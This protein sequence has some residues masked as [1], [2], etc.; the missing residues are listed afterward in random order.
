MK[1]QINKLRKFSLARFPSRIASDFVV[2]SRFKIDNPS[3]VGSCKEIASQ[4]Q[5]GKFQKTA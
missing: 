2:G 4:E 1:I 3:E 5:E